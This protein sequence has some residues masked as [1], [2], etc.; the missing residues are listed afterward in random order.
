MYV[1][2]SRKLTT[3]NL[4][5]I[6][7]SEHTCNFQFP[8]CF[9]AFAVKS[10]QATFLYWREGRKAGRRQLSEHENHIERP[11][12]ERERETESGEPLR[13]G[14]KS[15][16]NHWNFGVISVMLPRK[17]CCL[18]TCRATFAK[19]ASNCSSATWQQ[20]TDFRYRLLAVAAMCMCVWFGKSLSCKWDSGLHVR[21]YKSLP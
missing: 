2:P 19:C 6:C 7:Q 8:I 14:E 9:L 13:I 17:C 16:E 4:K 18:S 5:G 1:K 3:H 11:Q 10:T 20:L 21:A 12:R 15:G